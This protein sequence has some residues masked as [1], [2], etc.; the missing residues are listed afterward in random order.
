MARIAA[1]GLRVIDL[2]D[3][4]P[5]SVSDYGCGFASVIQ[6][7]DKIV[8]KVADIPV[9]IQALQRYHDEMYN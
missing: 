9:L 1:N 4:D 2:V 6:D 5:I 3:V 7:D 8:I